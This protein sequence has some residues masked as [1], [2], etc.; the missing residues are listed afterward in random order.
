MFSRTEL[1]VCKLLDR[2]AMD[3]V[4]DDSLFVQ[5]ARVHRSPR[6]ELRVI[7]KRDSVTKLNW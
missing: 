5:V 3:W 2:L 1:P 4:G 6:Y 7:Q